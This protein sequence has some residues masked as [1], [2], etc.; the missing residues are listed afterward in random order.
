MAVFPLV[1]SGELGSVP[2][3][4][5]RE[6]PS[7]PPHP[8]APPSGPWP[9]VGGAEGRKRRSPSSFKAKASKLSSPGGMESL[10]GSD[11][12]GILASG[13]ES[14]RQVGGGHLYLTP[15]GEEGVV[16]GSELYWRVYIDST[17][18]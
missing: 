9:Y 8:P 15:L 18:T 14:P 3:S 6:S 13:P 16:S 11:S 7:A 10:F 12:V 17:V 5:S 1:S 4:P 2:D